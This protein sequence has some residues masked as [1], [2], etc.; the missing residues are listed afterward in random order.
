M[1]NE[2]ERKKTPPWERHEVLMTKGYLKTRFRKVDGK[3]NI[4]GRSHYI[5][6]KNMRVI[7]VAIKEFS[8]GI[9]YVGLYW[10]TKMSTTILWIFSK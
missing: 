5:V 3:K 4:S 9:L 6:N 8:S 7:T 1:G 10:N 2:R